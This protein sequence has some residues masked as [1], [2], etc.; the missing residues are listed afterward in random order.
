MKLHL[1]LLLLAVLLLV[2]VLLFRGE[3]SPEPVRDLSGWSITDQGTRYLDAQGNPVTGWFTVDGTQYYFDPETALPYSGWAQ[4][5]GVR[6]YLSEGLPVSGWA[7]VDGRRIYLNSDGTVHTGWLREQGRS[8]Y[9]DEA[10]DPV[11]GWA[12]TSTGRFYFD[13]TGLLCTGLT[14]IGDTWYCFNQDGTIHTGW[15]RQ[16]TRQFYANNDGS[17]R[18]GW[19]EWD[20]DTY[21]LLD[22]GTPAVGKVVID[23]ETC[24]FSS[25]GVMFPLVNPWNPLAEENNPELVLV[26][27]NY[28]AVECQKDL[29]QMLADCRAAG[30]KPRIMSGHRSFY[31]Q[32]VTLQ[33]AISARMAKGMSYQLA[34]EDAVKSVAIPGTSE[35]HLGLALDIVDANNPK[36]EEFQEDM[37]T[38][39]WLMENCWKYGFILRYPK[40]TTEITGITYE[41]WHYRYVGREMAEEIY[42]L[43]LTLEEYVDMLTDDGTTCGGATVTKE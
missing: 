14:P 17:I 11:T 7:D 43:G 30:Y 22:N 18:T 9:L 8:W 20:A 4:R 29:E 37:P 16:G 19:L 1:P 27:N 3:V 35:H 31:I 12:Q 13:E 5:E 28:V 32:T 42:E 34:S 33:R 38:Q 41:P 24:F 10:G 23:G 40:G 2:G 26:E 6:C 36:L 21:Y 25:T 39:K 15:F